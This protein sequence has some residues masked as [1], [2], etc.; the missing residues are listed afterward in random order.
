MIALHPDELAAD[1]MQTYGIAWPDVEAG[2]YPASFVA[3]LAVQLPP[4]ARVRAAEDGDSMWRLDHV[5]LANLVNQLAALTH[6]L[7]GRKGSRP[8]KRIGPSYMAGKPDERKVAAKVVPAE[9]MREKMAAFARA[10][11]AGKT[12]SGE[13]G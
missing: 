9:Q 7:C 3:Q 8:P 4:D 5:L 13:E 10:A 1:M 2:R 11:A 6:A 12:K